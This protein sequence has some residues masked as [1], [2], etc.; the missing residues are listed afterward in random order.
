MPL[1]ALYQRASDT[2]MGAI[3]WATYSGNCF[4]GSYSRS[5][6][7]LA[8]IG[9]EVVSHGGTS[10]RDITRDCSGSGFI[11]SVGANV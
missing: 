9:R 4:T 8:T 6:G 2:G 5:L 3:C 7:D 11:I 10:E 1:S